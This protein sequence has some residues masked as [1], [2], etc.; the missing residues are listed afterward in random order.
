MLKEIQAK[1]D[2]GVIVARFQVH[3]LH[4]AHKELIDSVLARHSR[5]LIF[6]GL[7][8]LRNTTNNPLDFKSRRKMVQESYPDIEVFYIEDTNSDEIWSAKLD[9]EIQRWVNPG[10]SVILY[11]S[12]DSFIR[13]YDGKHK[14]CEL[15]SNTY[16][17]G[18]EIR[19]Q[20]CNFYPVTKDFRAGQIAATAQRFPTAYQAVDIAVFNDRNQLLLGA[21]ELEPKWRFIGGFSD[22]KSLSLEDDAKREVKE[23]ADI[24]I[25]NIK[26]VGSML[27]DDFRYRKEKDKVKTVL[28]KADYLF[29]SIQPNDDI[30]LLKWFDFDSLKEDDFMPEHAKLFKMLKERK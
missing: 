14:T 18:T 9:K 10:N 17:S 22:P 15:E 6:L 3:E 24:E 29:G 4:E 19:N 26:Y 25:G 23:E 11:G 5:V 28:F 8:P 16:V 13:H 27:I 2:V 7:S 20:I 30:H 21:K 12:R 1:A